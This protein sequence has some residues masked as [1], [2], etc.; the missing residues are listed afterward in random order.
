MIDTNSIHKGTV[1]KLEGNLWA[2]IEFQHV[3]PGKGGAFVRTKL[4]NVTTGSIMEKTFRSGDKVEDAQIEERK[5]TFQYQDEMFHFMDVQNFETYSLPEDVVGTDKQWMKENMEVSIELYEGRPITLMLPNFVIMKV[6][7]SENWVKG[8]TVS[9]SLKPVIVE[10]GA[11][12]SVPL[13]IK[14]DELIKIDTR[15]GEYIERVNK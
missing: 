10:T 14:Q 7:T 8:D 13:F 3:N 9:G 1:L 2:T 6:T 4:K 15:S 5:A 11:S 12:V